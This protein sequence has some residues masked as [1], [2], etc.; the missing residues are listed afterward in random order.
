MRCFSKNDLALRT[1][2]DSEMES[3]LEEMYSS[4]TVA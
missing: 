3:I 1:S 4:D 2:F